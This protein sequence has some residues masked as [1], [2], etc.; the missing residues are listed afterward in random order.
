MPLVNQILP[1]FLAHFHTEIIDVEITPLNNFVMD[2]ISCWVSW[3]LN[4]HSQVFDC[5][6][7]NAA[8][9]QVKSGGFSFHSG[10]NINSSDSEYKCISTLFKWEIFYV[11]TIYTVCVNLI[12]LNV[13]DL[14]EAFLFVV[15][16]EGL[17]LENFVSSKR[18]SK[19]KNI[20]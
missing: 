11:E 4:L 5:K 17:V 9:Y 19:L 8:W 7:L 12:D 1:N 13:V 18:S 10:I 15:Y 2:L 20:I 16:V 6:S 14:K 3:N